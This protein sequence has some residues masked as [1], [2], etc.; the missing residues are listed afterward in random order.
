MIDQI[1]DLQDRLTEMM[2]QNCNAVR[3]IEGLS[4]RD[5]AG[6]LTLMATVAVSHAAFSAA[7][8]DPALVNAPPERQIED[9]LE[10]LRAV[11][12]QPQSVSGPFRV[13]PGDKDRT[14]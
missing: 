4:D 9:F 10:I 6:T 12:T 1:R 7:L 3:K 11:M 13:V 14:P 2:H 8:T 5:V